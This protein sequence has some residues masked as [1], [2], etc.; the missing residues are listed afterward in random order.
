MPV[1]LSKNAYSPI[2]RQLTVLDKVNNGVG[3][4][5]KVEPN[6]RHAVHNKLENTLPRTKPNLLITWGNT[7]WIE[8]GRREE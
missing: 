1:T 5:S 8:W 2:S 7:K 3:E 4:D 6:L